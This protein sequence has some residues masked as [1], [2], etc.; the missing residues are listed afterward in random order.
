MGWHESECRI[1][2]RCKMTISVLTGGPSCRAVLAQ[3]RLGCCSAVSAQHRHGSRRSTG[4]QHA[5]RWLAQAVVNPCTYSPP[6]EHTHS[7]RHESSD[8]RHRGHCSQLRARWRHAAAGR[9]ACCAC[10]GA[11]CAAERRCW[12]GAWPGCN[13][14]APAFGGERQRH[15]RNCARCACCACFTRRFQERAG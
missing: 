12:T 2:H 11:C 13:A 1:H 8:Q 6:P 4:S 10:C 3:P 14:P 15:V 5:Q 7:P 9:W